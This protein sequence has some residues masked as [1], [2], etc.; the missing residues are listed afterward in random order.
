MEK[1]TLYHFS[2]EFPFQKQVQ[3]EMLVP[4]TQKS[5]VLL[6]EHK[7]KSVPLQ[8]WSGPEGSR[9]LRFPDFMTTAQD[10]GEVV[11]L[12][13]RQHFWSIASYIAETETP[14]K[15]NKKLCNTNQENAQFYKLIFNF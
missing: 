3:C 6:L 4:D 2:W 1:L 10:G 11:S 13:H 15:E 9:K 7:G 5:E 8:A 14:R 12:T